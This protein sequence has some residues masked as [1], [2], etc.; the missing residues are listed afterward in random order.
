AL[1]G[2]VSVMVFDF[3]TKLPLNDEWEYAWDVGQL[4]S[5]AG[6]HSFP[7]QTATAIVQ[8]IWAKI[9]TLGHADLPLLRISTLVA[10]TLAS[11]AMYLLARQ[12]GA[13]R[14]WAITAAS[15]P[16]TSPLYLSLASSFMT[17]ITYL[18]LLLPAAWAG[19]AWVQQ[20]KRQVVCI[21]FVVLATL[22]R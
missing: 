7:E 16:M 3:G 14:F 21:V 20:G 17:D 11:V 15:V 19:V 5:G 6:W 12:V 8:I 22:E 4:S 1:A 18:G 13:N 10:V 9:A 2:V